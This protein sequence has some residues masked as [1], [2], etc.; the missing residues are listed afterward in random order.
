[1]R[2]IRALIPV[3]ATAILFAPVVKGQDATSISRVTDLFS[4]D[5]FKKAGLS[6]LTPAELNALNAAFFRVVVELNSKSASSISR[7]HSSN[8]DVTTEADFY[9]KHGNAVAY[10][11]DDGDLTIYLWS[12]EPIAYLDGD[13]VY[14]FNGK[15]LGWFR[16]GAI[17]DHDGDVV[18]AIAEK[19]KTP[20]NI[21]PIKALQELTPLKSLEEL[22]PLEPLW[23]LTWSQT[24]ARVFFL[25]GA[26]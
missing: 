14:G 8:D 22:A 5:E 18:A 15:H 11:A 10:I 13:N 20:V 9:D 6:K 16:G 19:F 3:L 17:Y 21:A 1:M 26:S 4:A 25:G 12:G 7:S 2:I 23:S 24:P